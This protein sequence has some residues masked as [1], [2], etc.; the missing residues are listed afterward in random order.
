MV[1]SSVLGTAL[2][3]ASG[4]TAT[5]LR[6]EIVRLDQQF[7]QESFGF[8]SDLARLRVHGEAL[9]ASGDVA[10]AIL[11]FRKASELDAPA[12]GREYLARAFEA[13]AA[14]EPIPTR[15]ADLRRSAMKAYGAT[16]LRPA[17]LWLGSVDIQPGYYTA[18]RESYR[19]VAGSLRGAR[20]LAS[21]LPA[22]SSSFPD[23]KP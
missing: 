20:N 14:R 15:A 6:Q 12:N 18:Q 10:D 4:P 23:P 2:F 22:V 16:A 5:T 9:L 11:Q 13:A 1:A 19:R 17:L 8:I 7:P 21:A 3:K